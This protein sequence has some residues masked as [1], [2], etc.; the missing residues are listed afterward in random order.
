MRG[1][2]ELRVRGEADV[3]YDIGDRIGRGRAG[4]GR[5]AA[6]AADAGI[7]SRVLNVVPIDL[8]DVQ[9]VLDFE[10][11]LGDNAVGGAVDAVGVGALGGLLWGLRK[12]WFSQ[13]WVS[14]F[15]GTIEDVGT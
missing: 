14:S 9:V 13:E 7:E 4:D 12:A 5:G 10:H 15:L 11:F 3:H 1:D 6:A 8:S 2:E